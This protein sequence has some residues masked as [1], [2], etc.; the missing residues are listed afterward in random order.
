MTSSDTSTAPARTGARELLNKVPEVTVFFWVIKVLSTTVGETFADFLNGNVG[1]GDWNTLFVMTTAFVVVLTIQF[2]LRRYAAPAYWLTVVLISVVGTLITDMMTDHLGVPLWAS[3]VG[4]SV[5][6]AATFATWYRAEGT[7]SI[8]SIFTPRREAWYWLTILFTFALG[9]AAG[10]LVGEQ[11]N[12]GYPVA[13]ALFAAVIALVSAAYYGLGINPVLA[14]WL[15]YILT[16]PLGA[17]LGDFLSQPDNGG[18]GLGTTTTSFVFLGAIMALVAYLTA[19]RTDVQE[20]YV[21]HHG[22]H[23]AGDLD[24]RS[25]V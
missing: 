9:T 17:S 14:F 4:F 11:F 16:R 13:L 7:L 24:H 23:H 18:L 22:G 25:K 8:H 15:T 21:A 10:D 3:T 2:Q 5:A 20:D 6:L 19:T 12:L 1:L